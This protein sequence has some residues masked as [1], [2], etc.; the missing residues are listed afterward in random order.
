[1]VTWRLDIKTG[2]GR[3]SEENM[4]IF[5]ESKLSQPILVPSIQGHSGESAIHPEL[6]D[7]ILLPK[8]FTEYIYHVTNAS[9]LNSIIRNGLIPGEKASKE[10]DKLCCSSLQWIRWRTY[11]AWG[12][13]PCDL[14]KPRIAPYK[15]T[16][17]RFPNT[18]FWCSLK[19][20]QERG[21]QFYQT[22]SHAVT[23]SR[24]LQHTDCSLHWESGMY[25]HYGWA[26]PEGSLNSES[27]TS[28]VKIE[29]S[30]WSARSTEPRRNIILGTINRLE[31]LRWNL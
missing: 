24:S 7:N 12:E 15:T 31:K 1:M 19:F 25:E 16:W 2:Q 21:L 13:T 18:V 22:R 29:L 28:R 26:L 11:M 20:A 23:C 3:R 9:E 27:A 10:E 6:E 30:I 17:K 14:T 4:P 5:C 8:G